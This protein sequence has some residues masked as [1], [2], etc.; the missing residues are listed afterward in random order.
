MIPSFPRGGYWTSKRQ[1]H[2]Q[3]HTSNKEGCER[4]RWGTGDCLLDFSIGRGPQ[5]ERNPLRP[6]FL[7]LGGFMPSSIPIYLSPSQSQSPDCQA[8][9]QTRNVPKTQPFSTISFISCCSKTR[10]ALWPVPLQLPCHSIR[11]VPPRTH[12]PQ[13]ET[14]RF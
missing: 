4:G 8:R 11:T 6:I 13:Q 3:G 2:W 14:G 10:P 12:L 9:R 7:T 1:S 5:S